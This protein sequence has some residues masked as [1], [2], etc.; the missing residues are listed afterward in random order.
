MAH[1]PLVASDV[2]I[3][4]AF[5]R[6]LNDHGYKILAAAWIYD[7]DLEQWKLVLGS[8]EAYA[9][10]AE[11]YFEASH[12]LH[13]NENLKNRFRLARMKIVSLADPILSALANS[14]R[15]YRGTPVVRLSQ[16]VIDGHYVDDAVVYDLAV[17]AA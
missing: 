8:D 16:T 13:N 9:K 3:G 10:G 5:V 11:A 1:E 6:M 17:L 12:L 15:P 7:T 4:E 2:T 14:V